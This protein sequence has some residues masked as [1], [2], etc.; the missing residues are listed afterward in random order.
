MK[1]I[2]CILMSM[3]FL[4]SFTA[5]NSQENEVLNPNEG[6]VNNPSGA[7]GTN[8]NEDEEYHPSGG[9]VRAPTIYEI[10]PNDGSSSFARLKLSSILDEEYYYE[11]RNYEGS[12]MVYYLVIE[13]VIEEDYYGVRE[14]GTTVYLPIVLSSI[15]IHYFYEQ[16]PED[17]K[18]EICHEEEPKI[19]TQYEKTE[20]IEWLMGYDYFLAH[21][22]SRERRYQK[23]DG[24]QKEYFTFDN[25]TDPC[26]LEYQWMIPIKDNKVDLD[27]RYKDSGYSWHGDFTK[28]LTDGMPL[29][30]ASENL[31]K[32]AEKAKI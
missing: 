28:Y 8:P 32:L 16:D 17:P 29:D 20:V 7:E 11:A 25:M 2:L 21:F 27:H 12:L 14:S 31:R 4:L 13:C 26:L 23:R 15:S 6:E 1:K 5:C 18:L 9:G 10:Y 30:A 24:T 19:T 3:L 22:Y